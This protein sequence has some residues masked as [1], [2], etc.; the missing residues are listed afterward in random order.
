VAFPPSARRDDTRVR[1]E[2]GSSA[3]TCGLG[4]GHGWRGTGLQEQ[5]L[6]DLAGFALRCDGEQLAGIVGWS[7]DCGPNRRSASSALRRFMKVNGLDKRR[8][9]TSR[10]TDGADRAEERFANRE[11]RGYEAE[12]VG[13][14]WHWDC[15]HGSK[16]VLTGRGE[17]VTPILFGVAR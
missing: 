12:Y 4:L 17:W 3:P 9:V 15:H 13:S 7:P 6:I 2:A 16:K 5:L 10:Q 11:I 14:L 8:R 1:P